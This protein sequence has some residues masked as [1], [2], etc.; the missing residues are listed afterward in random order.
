MSAKIIPFP[1]Y[2]IVREPFSNLADIVRLLADASP[3]TA[4]K[5]RKPRRK[6][7]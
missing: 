2:R 6:K 5:P 3:V 4:P 7:A 1:P